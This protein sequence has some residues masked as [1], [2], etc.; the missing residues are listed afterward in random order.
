VTGGPPSGGGAAH[1]RWTWASPAVAVSPVGA[2]NAGAEVLLADP[3]PALDGTV[4]LDGG[5]VPGDEVA[6]DGEAVPDGELD[7]ELV[8][9]GLTVLDG[10]GGGGLMGS[11]AADASADR[12]LWPAAL[13]A[14]TLKK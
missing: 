11:N 7:G 1:D 14:T 9:V 5:V 2:A 12:G 4:G 3:A 6:L 10:E 8:L 13:T